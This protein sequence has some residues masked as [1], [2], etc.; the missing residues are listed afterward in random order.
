MDVTGYII[1]IIGFLVVLIISV[2]KFS[3]NMNDCFDEIQ[4]IR[5]QICRPTM[6]EMVDVNSM[7][8]TSIVSADD[9]TNTIKEIQTEKYK[10][11][12][13]KTIAGR[14]DL[15]RQDIDELKKE[16]DILKNL[17]REHEE[18]LNEIYIE[19]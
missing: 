12:F 10:E 4:R 19:E 9:D 14:I 5:H 18:K 2:W 1:A 11:I 7:H 6:M 16:V 15:N 17:L 8:P 13:H 3:A